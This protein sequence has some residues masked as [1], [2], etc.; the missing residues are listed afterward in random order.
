MLVFYNEAA[1]L[2][3]GRPFGE[4]GEIPS[5]AFGEVLQLASSAGCVDGR[6]LPIRYAL[7]MALSTVSG[8]LLFHSHDEPALTGFQSGVYYVDATRKG[9]FEPVRDDAGEIVRSSDGTEPARTSTRSNRQ[10]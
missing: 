1:E 3:I 8:I 7:A 10:K 6:R 5:L 9:S 4:L 2:L